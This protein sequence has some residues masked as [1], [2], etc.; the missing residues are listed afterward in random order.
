MAIIRM[1][2]CAYF[3]YWNIGARFWEEVWNCSARWRQL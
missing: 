3:K 1:K 2:G